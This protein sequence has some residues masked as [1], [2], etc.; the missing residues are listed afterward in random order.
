[1]DSVVDLADDQKALDLSR[2]R[3]QLMLVFLQ[4]ARAC[5]TKARSSH[6]KAASK[7]QSPFTSLSECSLR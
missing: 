4:P 2:I 7:T 1:M 5:L 6:V 3:Y